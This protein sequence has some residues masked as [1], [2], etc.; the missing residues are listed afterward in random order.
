MTDFYHQPV[1]TM[2]AMMNREIMKKINKRK[3]K[4]SIS[5]IGGDEMFSGYYHHHL[6]YLNNVKKNKKILC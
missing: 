1:L 4:V 2:S 3:F 5:G 6:V